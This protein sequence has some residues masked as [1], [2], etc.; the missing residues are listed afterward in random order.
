MSII[1]MKGANNELLINLKNLV[2]SKLGAEGLEEVE[3]II[4]YCSS[5]G[6]RCVEFCPSL[7]RGLAYYTGPVYEVFFKDS[8]ITSSAAGGGR[9]DNMIGAFLGGGKEYPATGIAFGLEVITEALKQKQKLEKKSV[10]QVF[11]IPI[12]TEKQSIKIAEELR[13]EGVKTELDLM[14][15]GISKNL[16]YANSLG[17]PFAVII[18]D[19]ELKEKKVKL[20]D[21]KTGKEE[22]LSVKDVVKK[23][24]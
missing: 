4:N 17:I 19:K 22:L 11:V 7:A 12:K 10:T 23:V 13:K 9:Y 20:R 5:F 6:I 3:D 18:G 8:K 24:K 16:S 14:K 2:T 1:N 21:M 15:R